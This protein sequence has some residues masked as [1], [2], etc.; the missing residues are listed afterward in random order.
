MESIKQYLP[1]IIGAVVVIYV[2]R[3]LTTRTS[4][5]PQTQ[6]VQTPQVDAYAEARSKAFDAL[7]GLGIAQTQS[8]VERSRIAETSSLERLRIGAEE[9]INLSAL[10][11]QERLANLNYLQRDQDRQAQYGAIN[12][13]ISAQNTGNI[14]NSISQ[15]ISSVF[16]N[17]NRNVF[18]TPPTFPSSFSFGGGF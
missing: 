12:R 5:L 18:G 10:D 13:S 1:W 16:G 3:K 8:D 9:R 6:I 17:R 4:L 2:L 15:A 11:V 14:I 7:I